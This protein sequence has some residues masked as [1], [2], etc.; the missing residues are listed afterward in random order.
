[1]SGWREKLAEA[2]FALSV[3]CVVAASSLF[4]LITDYRSLSD[5]GAYA[6]PSGGQVTMNR[7]APGDQTRPYLPTAR[8][9]A[10]GRSLPDGRNRTQPGEASPM[11][12]TISGGK[13]VASGT[14]TPGTALEFTRFLESEAYGAAGPGEI[15]LHSPGGVVDEAIALARRIREEGLNTRIEPEAYCASSCPL[16][17]AAGVERIA[18]PDAWIGVHQAFA[19]AG[20]FGSLQDGIASAQRVAASAQDLL[21]GFGVDA[22]VWTFAMRTPKEQI[23]FFTAEQLLEFK[24]ATRIDP[25]T[26]A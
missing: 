9:V 19:A 18:H 8:P 4:L 14:I 26:A 22:H 15:A 23:Y 3:F 13:I 17:F 16:V 10:P 25:D 21:H 11:R 12:F 2:G 6:P 7:P 5:R 20:S 1:M 24:L